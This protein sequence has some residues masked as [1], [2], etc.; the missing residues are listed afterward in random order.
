[1]TGAAQPDTPGQAA[2]RHPDRTPET[3]HA[4]LVAHLVRFAGELRRRGV[5]VGLRD[6]IDAV[7]A[8][9]FI[10]VS[11]PDE[12]RT[13]LRTTL[14]VARRWWPAFEAAFDAMWRSAARPAPGG[15]GRRDR[16]S[17][18]R[19][20]RGDREN[21]A[22]LMRIRRRIEGATGAAGAE[23]EATE[24]SRPGYSPRALLRR[25]AFDECTEEDFL[26]MERL[27]ERLAH[28]IATRRSRRLVP[29]GT[30]RLIDLRR[31]FRRSLAHGGEW[32]DPARR[33]R[34][35]ERPHLVVLCDTS[36]S[37]DAY[38][39]FLLTFVLSLRTVARRVETFAF[40]TSLTRL[41]PWIA[42]GHTTATL[43]RLARNVEDWSGG[44]RIG[45][46][47]LAFA[48]DY[49]HST[50]RS[51]TTVLILSDGLD[52]GDVGLLETALLAIRRRARQVVWLNPLMGDPRYRPEARGMRAALPYVD[53]LVP[54]HDVESLEALLPLL[55]G[56]RG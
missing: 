22:P 37:M 44:T 13:A 7:C 25:K 41:T 43:E 23:P 42:R 8:L 26:A 5:P 52:R 15:S 2:P 4:D 46:C 31:S 29:S 34:A 3:G 14:K 50:L 19:R 38:S 33:E 54:A 39:R 56:R 51:D 53:R 1:M 9:P 6:E 20:W 18:A 24:G 55:A 17:V 12:V 10:D 21:V 35:V 16:G 40:N 30:G 32:I 45:E 48:D 47:L 11:D 27:L 49:A 36:G 28:R